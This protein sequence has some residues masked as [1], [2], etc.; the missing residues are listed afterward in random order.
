MA[1]CP[2]P[3]PPQQRFS[4]LHSSSRLSTPRCTQSP[5][6]STD[7]RLCRDGDDRDRRPPP[8]VQFRAGSLISAGELFSSYGRGED[9]CIYEH[10]RVTRPVSVLCKSEAEAWLSRGKSNRRPVSRQQMPRR[11][12]DQPRCD[13][14]QP[15]KRFQP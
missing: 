15:S 3:P 10:H 7:L 5:S 11:A 9:P 2:P 13:G 6:P 12:V 4:S 8:S 14:I 1:S